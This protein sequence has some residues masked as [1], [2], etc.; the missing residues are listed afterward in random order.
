MKIDDESVKIMEG[1]LKIMERTVS[2]AL[3]LESELREINKNIDKGSTLQELVISGLY[4]ARKEHPEQSMV[5]III[6]MSHIKG[7]TDIKDY[8]LLLKTEGI[9]H[10]EILHR[11]GYMAEPI[12]YYVEYTVNKEEE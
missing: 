8:H 7:D 9:H 5:S 6:P 11:N 10:I 4:K 12:G 3:L 2:R 1:K